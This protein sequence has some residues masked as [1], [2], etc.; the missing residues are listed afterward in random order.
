MPPEG[1]GPSTP[2]TGTSLS[3]ALARFAGAEGAPEGLFHRLLE[4]SPDAVVVVDVQGRILFVNLQ[5]EHLFDYPPNFL[6]GR[7]VDEL[8]PERLRATHAGHR[9]AFTSA[10]RLRPM[11]SGLSLFGRRR[12]GSEFPVEISLSPVTI[13]GQ[14]LF[15]ANIRD[16]SDRRRQEDQMRRMQGQLLSAVESIQGSFA[17]FDVSDRLV[18]CNSEYCNTLARGVAGP[19]VGRRFR[20]LLTESVAAGTFELEGKSAEEWMERW[21]RHHAAPA[22]MFDVKATDGRSLRICERR[23][24]DGG[25]VA[26]V[27]DVT[28]EVQHEEEL[29]SA[30]TLAEAASAAKTEFLASMSHELR[31]PLNAIL[32]FAQLLQRDKKTPLSARQQERIDHVMKGG[33]HLLRLIDDVLDLARIEA[34]RVLISPEPVGVAEVLAE[35]MD[36]LNP[37]ATRAGISL[38]VAPTPP[39]AREVIADC[40]HLRNLKYARAS[41]LAF[42]EHGAVMAAGI[43]RSP[44]AVETSILVVRAFVR[45]R[46]LLAAHADLA[47]RVADLEKRVGDHDASLRDLLGAI[48]ALLEPPEEDGEDRRGGGEGERIGFRGPGGGSGPAPEMLARRLHDA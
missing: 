12:D 15:S 16:I 45:M 34:G 6:I 29:R 14:T 8:V 32:G 1:E 27:W 7:S 4:T 21:Q 17:L 2:L 38:A 48:R 26:T 39:A 43:L 5:T 47:A 30:R 36:T 20:E 41:P 46:G 44:R 13:G 11:G 37:M 19:L 22:G 42:T 18:L 31:T 9:Q 28:D 35:V 3:S 25:V 10:P 24:A 33:E 23:T 40:D